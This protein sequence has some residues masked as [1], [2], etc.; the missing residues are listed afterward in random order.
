MLIK[1]ASYLAED[2]DRTFI[3]VSVIAAFFIVSITAFMIYSVIRYSR[4][5]VSQPKQFTGSIAA[6]VTWTAVAI[7]LVILMFIQGLAPYKKMRNVP[8]D[9]LKITAIGRMWQWEFDYGNGMRSKLLYIPVN[10]PIR[11]NL[12]SE[13]VNHSLF[14]P[15]FRVK[16]D[17]IPGYDNWLWFTPSDTGQYE[18]LCTEY[19][20]LLHSSMLSKAIVMNGDDYDKWF[21]GFQSQ[22]RPPEPDGYLL[23]RNNGCIACHSLDGSKLVGPSFKGLF[24]KERTVRSGNTSGI[25][26]ADEQYI[27]KSVFDPDAEV[28]QGFNR[29][30]MKS[31]SG[32]LSDKDVQ[33]IIDYLKTLSE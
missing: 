30:L 28:V 12:R 24:G 20:G 32:V 26:I 25:I 1:D 23:I 17:A 2:V 27:K 6:E 10:K 15:A 18:I 7:V 19:C 8:D 4:K 9:A 21:A 31:Y 11:I 14:I 29:G 5:K 16:Q 22:E 33:V 3:F 13:D